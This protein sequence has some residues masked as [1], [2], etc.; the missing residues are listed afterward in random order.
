[1]HFKSRQMQADACKRPR[2]ER[3]LVSRIAQDIERVWVR[4][5]DAA[6]RCDER[7]E[8][9][10]SRRLLCSNEGS[11]Q[12][13]ETHLSSVLRISGRAASWSPY[14]VASETFHLVPTTA[15]YAPDNG[16]TRAAEKPASSIQPMQ[17]APLKSKP[18]R[19]SMSMFRLISRPGRRAR[20]SSSISIS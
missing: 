2:A 15:L 5:C 13:Q 18:P 4:D 17:S 6:T 7:C 14:S 11:N 16:T 19:V 8:L 9:L 1:M 10:S 3:Q 20:R 12:R